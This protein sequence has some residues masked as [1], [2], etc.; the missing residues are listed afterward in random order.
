[1]FW[2][3]WP[4]GKKKSK[5]LAERWWTRVKP[6]GGQL[7]LIMAGLT[8]CKLSHDWT[9][10]GGRFIPHPSSWLSAKGWLDEVEP[11][12]AAPKQCTWSRCNARASRNYGTRPVCETHEAAYQRGETP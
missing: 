9:K 2:N 5:G 7:A 6:D 11:A 8:A 10:E 4:K 3:S 12:A 1:M